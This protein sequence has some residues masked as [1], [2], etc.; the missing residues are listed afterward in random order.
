MEN[1]QVYVINLDHRTDR[2]EEITKE[3]D[4]MGLKFKRFPAI[5]TSP[6]I[7]G[8]GLSHLAVL[9]E[10]RELGLK[11]VLIF[12]DDFTFSESK[13]HCWKTVEE[14]LKNETYDVVMFGYN[15]Q[16]SSPYKPGLLKVL[17]A[18]TA[19]AY[20]VNHRF[21]DK[22]I[23]L[24]EE[25]MPLLQSTGKHWV[26]A[27]DEVWKKLQPGADWFAFE[28]RMGYQRKSFSDNTQSVTDYRV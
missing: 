5:K 11:E 16:K 14:F 24:F 18:Q 15:M 19:S 10:A 23:N 6:G 12:E 22:L 13:E 8:C 28:P 20:I 9:K 7:I 21:Y 26:Y 3:L 17:E 2:L 4:I 1:L 27:N 25:A